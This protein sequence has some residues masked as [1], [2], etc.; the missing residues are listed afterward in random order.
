M[1]IPEAQLNTWANQG[2]TTTSADTY[3]SVETALTRHT[4]P[5]GMSYDVYLQG[6]YANATNIRADS[7][8][9][10]ICEFT[11]QFD[12]NLTPI[13]KQQLGLIAGTYPLTRFNS[14]V[15][16]ALVSHYGR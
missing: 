3:R 15:L 12:S 13:G 9:D 6:S 5:Q 8:V 14:E 4:W 1:A 11:S 16:Q 7:D 2:A 10:V